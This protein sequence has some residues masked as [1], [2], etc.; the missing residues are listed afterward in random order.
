MFCY[1]FISF[2]AVVEESD[3]EDDDEENTDDLV[4]QELGETKNVRI[5]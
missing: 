2:L 1:V 3:D 4:A 5:I